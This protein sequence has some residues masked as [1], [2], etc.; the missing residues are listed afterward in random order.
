MYTPTHTQR[1]KEEERESILWLFQII[2]I[3]EGDMIVTMAT[4]IILIVM[5]MFGYYIQ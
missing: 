2:K 3:I 1:K 5:I 4:K